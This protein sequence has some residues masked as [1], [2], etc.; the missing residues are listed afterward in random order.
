M[1]L[2]LPHLRRAR[3][4]FLTFL[5]FILG[6]AVLALHFNE[7][8]KYMHEF[9]ANF[10]VDQQMI[11]LKNVGTGNMGTGTTAA[12]VRCDVLIVG[13]G[14][15]GTF[16]AIQSARDGASTCIVEE[17][18]WIGGMI[19]AAG[20]SSLDGNAWNYTGLLRE[21]VDRVKA[22]YGI[23]EWQTV[24]CLAPFCFEPHIGHQVLKEMVSQEPNIKLFLKT[25][26]K[27]VLRTDNK[28]IGV[29]AEQDGSDI[30]FDAPVTIDA[31]ELG[32]VMYLGDVPFDLGADANSHEP[33]AS[34]KNACIQPITVTA[35]IQ[36]TGTEQTPV[37]AT[38]TYDPSNFYCT[39]PSAEC[40]HSSTEFRDWKFL[41]QYGKFPNG[42]IM[43]NIPT[44]SYGNDFD[45]DTS[46]YDPLSRGAVIDL[47]R[48]ATLNIVRYFQTE[49]E[50][51]TY[52]LV[53]EF[54]TPDKLSVIPYVRESR[55]LRGVTRLTEGD[56][57]PNPVNGQ[58]KFWKDAIAV[59]DYPLDIHN[60]ERG[61]KDIFL[62]YPPFQVPY[63][64]LIPKDVDGLIAAEK[65]I[66]VSH[67]A[68]GRTRLQPIVASVGQ[69]AGAAAAMA[70]LQHK[71]PRDI[72]VASLQD[73][74]IQS[75]L[76]VNFYNDLSPDH[77]AFPPIS[78]LTQQDIVH[79]YGDGSFKPDQRFYRAEMAALLIRTFG[80]AEHTIGQGSVHFKDVSD[81]N[82]FSQYAYQLPQSFLAT[83]FSSR[84]FSPM[85]P[86]TRG[87]AASW[88]VQLLQ[89]QKSAGAT[90]AQFLDL[91]SDHPFKDAIDIL[92]SQGVLNANSAGL[93]R[94][95]DILSRAE[96]ATLMYRVK[97]VRMN[98]LF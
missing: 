78:I 38:D 39:I 18:D 49:L 50:K 76:R 42:K 96:A 95:N 77:W 55:R 16:A 13:G 68:N 92:N 82:W 93:I 34:P 23:K 53:N 19:T 90:V 64:A 21:F 54:G 66:S 80:A 45:I 72:D 86:I 8:R 48:K 10:F 56:V 36:D 61:G 69:A 63:S 62:A 41:T 2:R 40:R 29:V 26:L 73:K 75:K 4:T 65:N 70:S 28:I 12:A 3:L 7:L 1:S 84:N 47:A 33:H 24:E 5:V 83:S 85:K 58:M 51:S 71:Q 97:E 74:L 57:T 25:R 14:T 44:H 32:D 60:C 52:K 79:G 35:I 27:R 88:M 9:G 67:I 11:A 89:L 46:E 22:Q 94:P 15:G 31:T 20:V 91:P 81:D 6:F 17:T 87:E 98:S 59:G 37:P 30:T 43:I